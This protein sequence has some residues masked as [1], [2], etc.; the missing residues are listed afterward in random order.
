MLH[1]IPLWELLLFETWSIIYPILI[2][3]EI[4]LKILPRDRKKIRM[5]LKLRGGM[6]GSYP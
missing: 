1:L 3:V 6:Q 4:E 5:S 2:R